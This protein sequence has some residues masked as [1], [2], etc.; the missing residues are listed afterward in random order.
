MAT[1]GGSQRGR[2]R[3]FTLVELLVVIAIIGVLIAL[4]LPAIQAAREAAR[5]V[6]CT[7]NQR[8]CAL[9]LLNYET[10]FQQFPPGLLVYWG[11]S[12]SAF[13]LGRIEQDTVAAT[14]PTP[15][16][17][18]GEP[19]GTT[20]EDIAVQNL[21][22]AQVF[23]FRCPSQNGELLEEATVGLIKDRFKTNYLGCTGWNAVT[24]DYDTG[25]PIDMTESNGMFRVTTCQS[26]TNPKPWLIRRMN[27]VRDGMANT[28]MIGESTYASTVNDGCSLCHRFSIYHP[29][30]DT[31]T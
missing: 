28:F 21:A 9:A 8:Q 15:W 1:G 19:T 3:G 22:R 24:P 17:D 6:N 4:L 30:F 16:S 31:L 14:I 11:Y 2:P 18:L 25:T 23:T 13:T 7:S 29:E 27:E 5:R 26:T 12:W 10:S 20:K